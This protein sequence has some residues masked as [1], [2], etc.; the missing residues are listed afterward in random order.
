MD[1]TKDVEAPKS[2][3]TTGVRITP[4]KKPL[5]IA[6]PGSDKRST[7]SYSQRI[8][9]KRD[10]LAKKEVIKDNLKVT[11]QRQEE[12]REIYRIPGSEAFRWMHFREIP[13]TK[14]D[15]KYK[16]RTWP[17]FSYALRKI[18]LDVKEVERRML[19][20]KTP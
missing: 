5:E 10:E 9:V 20:D 11:H 6:K 18:G 3:L 7:I 16:R 17:G 2:S 13:R 4:V 14:E 8:P 1:T 15:F 12:P 19:K